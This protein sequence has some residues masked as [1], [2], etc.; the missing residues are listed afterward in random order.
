MDRDVLLRRA[1]EVIDAAR[2]EKLT[3]RLIGG[4][5][6][7][8]VA[9][10]G[11]TLYPR[12][13]KDVD[14]FGLSNESS[15]LSK[16]MESLGMVPNK[17]FNALRGGTRLM[18][19]DPSLDSTV[20]VFLDEFVMCHRLSLKSRLTIMDYTIPPSDLILTKLQIVKMTE[21]DVR[22][23]MALLHDLEPSSSDGQGKFD[24]GYVTRLLGEDWGFYTTVTDN[25]DFLISK[26]KE[27]P[28][29]EV[30]ESKAR[31][32]LKSLED[33][34]KSLKWKLRARVG[35]R[36]KWYEEPEEVGGF[37]P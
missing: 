18:F 8:I 5:A 22:D 27:F 6:V 17:R 28:E 10:K 21:N 13:Y 30:V 34:P 37:R 26:A 14:Y 29:G 4:A 16:F 33:A 20:D 15:K 19:Y 9:P 11:S 25:L 3:L 32:L 35:R 31:N 36:S 24:L 2:R 12:S 1:M 23:T 7:A